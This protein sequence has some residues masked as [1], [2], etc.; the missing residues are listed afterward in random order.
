MRYLVASACALFGILAG[1]AAAQSAPA[2]D[3]ASAAARARD[4][5]VF[6]EQFFNIDRAYTPEA[7]AEAAARLRRLK[8]D[9][10]T[11]SQAFFELELA[12]IAALADNGH[13][14]PFSNPRSRVPLRLVPFGEDFYVLRASSEYSDL[15]GGR[16]VSVDGHPIAELRTAARALT[17]GATGWRDRFAP[18]FL[19]SPEQMR[20]LAAIGLGG[21]YRFEMP[22]GRIVNRDITPE[23]ANESRPSNDSDRWL[24]PELLPQE[25]GWR[26]LLSP[27]RAPWSLREPD[28]RFRWRAAPEI[29]GLVIELRQNNN[30]RAQT[31]AA[32]IEEARGAIAE[33]QPRN[34]VLDM[35]LNGGGDLNTTRDL[36]QDLPR[37][38]PGRIFVLTSPW[39][40]SAAISSVGYLKQA[41]PDRVTIVGE[42]VGDRLE[43]FAEG[44]S[45]EL[46]HSHAG[47]LYATERHDYVNGCQ[48][49]PDCHG[50]V[51]RHPI[52]VPSLSPEIAAPWTLE[53]YRAGRDPAM[54]A[55]IAALRR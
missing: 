21:T 18:Y 19:E 22:D 6:R 4:I 36:M 40:F 5:T 17:G 27:D 46:P 34:I 50:S 38:A 39:T 29:D 9:E 13:T 7:R 35:R 53:T 24:S 44:R 16:L 48:A 31:I 10:A 2:V 1:Q 45:V 43:F 49:F 47:F 42:E 52:A 3:P 15:L 25:E 12:R 11:I 23:P 20:A 14:L 26:T 30:S 32:F 28:D 54:E 55:V 8:A 33:H 41:A 51:V 37:L